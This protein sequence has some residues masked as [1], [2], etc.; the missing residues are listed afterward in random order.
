VEVHQ[1]ARRPLLAEE[2]RRKFASLPVILRIGF[3]VKAICDQGLEGLVRLITKV[4][5]MTPAHA[6]GCFACLVIFVVAVTIQRRF[7]GKVRWHKA[8]CFELQRPG[9]GIFK[10]WS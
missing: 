4:R 8:W 5:D 1:A 3:R 7:T 10:S 2:E 9:F 6:L